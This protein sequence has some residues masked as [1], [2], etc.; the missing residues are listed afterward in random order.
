MFIRELRFKNFCS[1]CGQQESICLD[2]EMTAFIGKNGSRK[3]T[4]L[5]AIQRLFGSTSDERNLRRDEVHFGTGEVFGLPL[6]SP[7]KHFDVI[8]SPGHRS[9]DCYAIARL[10]SSYE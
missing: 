7:Q 5:K 9:T 6:K 3:T 8:K 10:E 1:F 2:P 4:S